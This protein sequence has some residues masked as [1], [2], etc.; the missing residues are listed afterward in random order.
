MEE[1]PTTTAE[2][3]GKILVC[4]TLPSNTDSGALIGSSTILDLK[5]MSKNKN[6]QTKLDRY[7]L[8][9]ALYP[10]HL[11]FVLV[12]TSDCFEDSIHYYGDGMEIHRSQEFWNDNAEECQERCQNMDGKCCQ[13]Y[14]LAL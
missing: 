3:E 14:R 13:K 2:P 10:T 4:L 1:Q 7:S 9:H 8:W 6:G 11:N 5:T 12:E